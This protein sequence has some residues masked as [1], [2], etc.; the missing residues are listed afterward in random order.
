MLIFQHV[1]LNL[2]VGKHPL[3][4]LTIVCASVLHSYANFMLSLRCNWLNW[5]IRR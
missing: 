3:V 5:L 2:H 4:H 1:L